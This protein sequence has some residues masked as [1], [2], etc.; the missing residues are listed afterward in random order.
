MIRKGHRVALRRN[1]TEFKLVEGQ[2]G[3]V[4]AVRKL[5]IDPEPLALV[6]WRGKAGKVSVAQADLDDLGLWN[7][8][9]DA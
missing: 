1:L 2:I 4:V 6:K 7:V 8:K 9:E 3:K 5:S